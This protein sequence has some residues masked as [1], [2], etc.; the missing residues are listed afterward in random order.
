[1]IE[2]LSKSDAAI[3]PHL[4]TENNDATIPH[5]LFQ[6]MYLEIPVISSD[7]V[8]L[9]RILSEADTG[10]IYNS[11]SPGDLAALLE[12]LYNNRQLLN[13]KNHNGKNAVLRKYNWSAD[14]ERLIN[15]YDN[16]KELRINH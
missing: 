10:F 8:P 4:R 14:K 5:K 1:M 9:K 12:K 6:Y 7:C 3:I 2:L 11:N 15:A 16:L 13:E